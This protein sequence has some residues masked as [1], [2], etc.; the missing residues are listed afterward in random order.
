MVALQWINMKHEA[1]DLQLFFTEDL[2][3]KL[4]ELSCFPS[5]EVSALPSPPPSKVWERVKK[6]CSLLTQ[7]L[8]MEIRY[9]PWTVC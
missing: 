6:S 2:Y 4:V 3:S 9:I 7:F 5:N 8:A 1:T